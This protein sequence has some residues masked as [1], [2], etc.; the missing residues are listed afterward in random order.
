M[1]FMLR[2]KEETHKIISSDT[3]KVAEKYSIVIHVLNCFLK[4]WI[5]EHDVTESGKEFQINGPADLNP[6]EPNTVL[7]CGTQS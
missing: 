2:L 6:R 3:E 5:V 4:V 1:A 7:T